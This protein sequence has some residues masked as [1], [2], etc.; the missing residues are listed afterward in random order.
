[1]SLLFSPISSVSS[2]SVFQYSLNSFF[3]VL[4]SVGSDNRLSNSASVT[5]TLGMAVGLNFVVR[6]SVFKIS[7]TC[8]ASGSN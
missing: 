7:G 6:P 4:L 3:S 2:Y 1:M 8:R 5:L